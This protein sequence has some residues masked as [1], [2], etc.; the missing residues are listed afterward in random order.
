MR[1]ELL[2]NEFQ[3]VQCKQKRHI[4]GIAWYSSR[5]TM[6]LGNVASEPLTGPCLDTVLHPHGA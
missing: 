2:V 1:N 5:L 6:A 4:H 3:E